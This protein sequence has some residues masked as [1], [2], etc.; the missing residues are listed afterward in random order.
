MFQ[1][2]SAEVVLPLRA[3]HDASVEPLDYQ[4][5]HPAV[6]DPM[7]QKPDKPVS[8]QSIE[9]LSNVSVKY[10]V[11]LAFVDAVGKGVQRVMRRPPRPKPIAQPE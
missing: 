8:I 10:P 9:K 1:R 5:Y 11:D 7:F 6:P 4:P 2:G 3:F